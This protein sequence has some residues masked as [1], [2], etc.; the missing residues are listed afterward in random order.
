VVG[1]HFR[2]E[3][4][5][6]IDEVVVFHSLG[7][8]QIQHIAQIQLGLL[9]KRLE[10][11]ELKLTLDDAALKKLVTVGYDPVY[12]ARPLKRA[13][14]RWIENPLAQDILGGKFMPGTTIK[15]SLSGDN[16]IF[17]S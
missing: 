6:R 9:S 4:I 16:F 11:R 14:Q 5:N 1:D 8:E 7:E 10:E 3:F 15:A 2:P 12:G 13:I 17:T